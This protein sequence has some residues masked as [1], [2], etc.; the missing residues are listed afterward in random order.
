MQR[1]GE[2]IPL[3]HLAAQILQKLHLL[4]G[5]HAFGNNRNPEILRDVDD[6]RHQQNVFLVMLNI[7]DKCP[8]H[9]Q[10]VDRHGGEHI[11]GR[12]TGAEIVHLYRI[13]LLTQALHNPDHLARVLGIGSL[14]HLQLE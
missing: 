7:P 14:R 3:H 10:N 2:V 5:L 8:V 6:Q 13:P 1:P 9:L 12:I 11:Q 4:F